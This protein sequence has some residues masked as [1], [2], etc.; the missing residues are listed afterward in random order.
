MHR[1]FSVLGM[2]LTMKKKQSLTNLQRVLDEMRFDG[3]TLL[4]MHTKSGLAW[5]L[6]PGGEVAPSIVPKILEHPNIQPS[7]DGLFPG[8]SQTFKWKT[9]KEKRT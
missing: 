2:V 5:F 8:I 6:V 1:P 3:G 7:H 4:Q 9:Q